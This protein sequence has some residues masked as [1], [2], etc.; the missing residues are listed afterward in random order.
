MYA[1]FLI[2]WQHNGTSLGR[3]YVEPRGAEDAL[4]W[5]LA[6]TGTIEDDSRLYPRSDTG[7]TPGPAEVPAL[8]VVLTY[9]F[10]ETIAD[11][12]I[13]TSR[14]SLYA[15]GTHE[16]DS[17]WLQHA[18]PVPAEPRDVARTA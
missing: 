9:V 12:H 16:I 8:H 7:P 5:S 6:V 4:G 11:A 3:I 18:R 1:W 15:D 2:R 14:I 10:D 17:E 13:A